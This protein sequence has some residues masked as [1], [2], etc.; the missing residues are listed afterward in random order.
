MIKIIAAV[1]ING[2]IGVTED[3]GPKIPWYYPEDLKFFKDM[4]LNSTVVMGRKT[5]ETLKK[6]LKNRRN[7]VISK[8]LSTV[9]GVEVVKSWDDAI[10]LA[11]FNNDHDSNIWLIGG[12]SV[13]E[14]GL[15]YAEEIYLT[16]IPL[17]IV[18][19]NFNKVAKFPFIS[20][21]RFELLPLQKLSENVSV[22]K[23]I[24]TT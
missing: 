19:E 20:P 17:L 22:A 15:G 8:T 24:R 16:L 2:I 11:S 6:P 4:T 12:E 1:S 14:R 18:T 5:F 13:Y 21:L 9:S 3:S 7:I 10:D 23:Y